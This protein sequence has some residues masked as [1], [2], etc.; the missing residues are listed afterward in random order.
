MDNNQKLL[1]SRL[2]KKYLENGL[3]S[4]S[5]TEILELILSFSKKKDVCSVSES[6]LD[7]YGSI[8]NISKIDPKILLKD[9]V[10]SRQSTALIRLIA[11]M[12]RLY[13]MDKANINKI[14]C[15]ETAMNFLENYYI[16]VS[17]ERIAIIALEKDFTI[18]NYC[19]ISSGTNAD[20]KV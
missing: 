2:M 8:S 15:V 18:K 20:V 12:S 5:E 7:C 9:K 10:L 14:D 13:N 1:K 16:G 6:L 19:F 17:Y 3:A 11:V 4:M